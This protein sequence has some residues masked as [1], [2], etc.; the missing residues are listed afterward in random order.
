MSAAQGELES[1]DKVASLKTYW[2]ARPATR[3]D[4]ALLPPRQNTAPALA[5]TGSSRAA[6][7]FSG[8]SLSRIVAVNVGAPTCAT[9][10]AAATE[11]GH[12]AG[13]LKAGVLQARP[14]TAP[15][16]AASGATYA[17]VGINVVNGARS[18]AA[19]ASVER[20]YS[21]INS[22]SKSSNARACARAQARARAR[23]A[24][25]VARRRFRVLRT[26]SSAAV[27][28]AARSACRGR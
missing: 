18:Q 21:S 1:E 4:R 19:S 5:S 8:H 26:R 7:S 12:G 14:A 24:R 22:S 27:A 20:T 25:A 2:C 17:G 10:V 13:T 23:A 15:S 3:P 11:G 6:P 28:S 9:V 16:G